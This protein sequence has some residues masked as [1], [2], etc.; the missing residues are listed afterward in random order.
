M[1]RGSNACRRW[2]A[3]R[4]SRPRSSSTS[5]I[6]SAR[7]ASHPELRLGASPRSTV[8][9]YRAAQAWAFLDGST[10]RAAGGRPGRGAGRAGPSAARRYRSPAARDEPR[11]DRRDVAQIGADAPRRRVVIGAPGTSPK[12]PQTVSET[13]HPIRWSWL[14]VGL[15]L[16]GAIAATPGL[17]LVGALLVLSATSSATS[18]RGTACA[19]SLT[20]ATSCVIARCLAR[21]SS[22]RCRRGTTS[23][24]PWR[25][26]R[27]RISSAKDCSCASV[28]SAQRPTWIRGAPQH[29]DAR[30]VRAGDHAS[31]RHGRSARGLPVRARSDCRSPT[32]SDVTSRSGPTSPRC[33]PRP[34]AE[35]ARAA[36]RRPSW[37]RSAN[38]VPASV[39]TTTRAVRGRSAVPAHG[40]APRR[41]LA[42]DRAAG[43]ARQQAL[44]AGDARRT[45]IALDV[46][47][48]EE[49]YWMMVYEEDLLSR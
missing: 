7:R 16:V 31:P 4:R 47:T 25:G 43:P 12:S 26:S 6:S 18:G 27:P 38:G 30:P 22:C 37:R 28:P 41:A 3:S 9:M 34:A 39:F 19:A 24:C 8:A 46:Q 36:A 44:R 11:G 33:P 23:C 17:L 20:S 15:I 2:C 29:L 48:N 45:V 5:S 49:P 40:S 35:R 14:G 32:S 42:R 10:V 1:R 13:S 21:R